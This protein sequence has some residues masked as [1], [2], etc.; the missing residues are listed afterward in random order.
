MYSNWVDECV[1]KV[2]KGALGFEAGKQDRA[3]NAGENRG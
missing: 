3:R 2:V 1:L